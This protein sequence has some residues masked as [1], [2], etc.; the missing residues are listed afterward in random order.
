[1]SEL[2]RGNQQVQLSVFTVFKS[3]HSVRGSETCIL[4]FQACLRPDDSP[5]G[6]SQTQEHTFPDC[7]TPIP[8][9]CKLM[10]CS[11]ASRMGEKMQNQD[12]EEEETGLNWM[13]LSH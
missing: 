5:R 6:C 13:N 11:L 10:S 4:H 12:E 2:L 3:S 8:L 1:M 7:A 9:F